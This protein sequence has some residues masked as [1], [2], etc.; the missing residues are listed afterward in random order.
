MSSF[1]KFLSTCPPG[2]KRE[3][4]PLYAHERIGAFQDLKSYL[5]VSDIQVHC[6]SEGC[7]GV[8]NFAFVASVTDILKLGDEHFYAFLTYQCRN[9]VKS[10]K[11]FA[12]QCPFRRD[13]RMLGEVLKLGEN[14]AFGEP[15]PSRVVTLIR[16][17]RALFFKGRD[18]EY[19][20]L[21]IG[22]F[23][24]YRRVIENQK[25]RLFDE[26]IK[27]AKRLS[28]PT[29]QI[30]KLESAKAEK[31]FA[32]AVKLIHDA[33]PTVLLI[34]GLNPLLLL[35]NALSEGIHALTDE[36]CLELATDIREVLFAL[37]ERIEVALKEQKGLE[38]AIGR[39][40]NP[41]S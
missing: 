12:I 6:P 5:D 17:D 29:E 25:G 30:Q 32:N 4:Y 36:R 22:A 1:P 8:R 15:I 20:G 10:L 11:T 3:V 26:I 37:A 27:V 7:D 19:H 2:E 18:S 38:A 21:G 13:G 31:Q 33:I 16:E 14:P 35:H 24:Y 39:L 40:R 9:C 34:N 41:K 23:A 28:A